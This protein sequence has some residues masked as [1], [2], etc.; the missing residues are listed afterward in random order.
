MANE[1]NLRPPFSKDCPEI[2]RESQEKS[3]KARRRNTA[4]KKTIAETV[5]KLLN[6]PVKDEKQLSII[7]KS[8]MP[9]KGKPT[10][11]D[12]LVASVIMRT[13]KKGYVD[14]L[15]KLMD[16]LGEGPIQAD[17]DALKKAKE[18]LGAVDSAID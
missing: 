5:D 17:T 3:V 4:R 16:I 9:I 15:T 18:I 11:K 13:I 8:G 14:D 2:A 1:Q 7:E 12:F 6:E 10:Y